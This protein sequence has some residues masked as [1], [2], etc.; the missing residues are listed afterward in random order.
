MCFLCVCGFS[1]IYID[2]VC[3]C[4]MYIVYMHNSV[5]LFGI[6]SDFTLDYIHAYGF[7]MLVGGVITNYAQ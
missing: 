1:F 7:G 3:I 5:C 4:N 6:L 2:L